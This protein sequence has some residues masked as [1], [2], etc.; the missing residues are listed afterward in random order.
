MNLT[1]RILASQT[2]RKSL[3]C[4]GLDVEPSRHGAGT[5][6]QEIER[7]LVEAIRLTRDQVAGYKANLA[8]FLALGTEGI[9]MLKKLRDEIPSD[10]I[11]V[12]DGKWGDIGNT[13]EKYAEFG[14]KY[15]GADVLTAHPYMGRDGIEPFIAEE[16]RG[17]FLLCRTSNPNGAEIQAYPTPCSPLFMHV[18]Q[19]AQTWNDRNNIGLV[20][21][22]TFPQ[23]MKRIRQEC[24]SS[25]FLVPGVGAQGGRVEDVLESAGRSVLIAASRS[26]LYPDKDAAR[27][28][29]VAERAAQM[30]QEIGWS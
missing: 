9:L 27:S 18:A 7:F 1:E 25:I 2:K 15:L 17:V 28:E 14:F 20:V 10:S 30:N 12:L 8:F 22:A 23:E 3:V 26:L 19:R 16:S 4:V 11:Y 6:L 13:S 24:P 21:G 5:S 29:R